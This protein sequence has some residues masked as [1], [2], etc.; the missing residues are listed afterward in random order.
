MTR[1]EFLAK[2]RE[3]PRDWFLDGGSI[4]RQGLQGAQC[5]I[6]SL[7]DEQTAE[8]REVARRLGIYRAGTI[9]GAADFPCKLAFRKA[10]QKL[11]AQ[12]L[13][14]CGLTEAV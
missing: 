11:R 5:P 9:A 14:A 3:T 13:E 6:T 8:W 1:E 2:L 4:R 12:L 7:A 10:R